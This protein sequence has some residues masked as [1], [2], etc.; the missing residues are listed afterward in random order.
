[1]LFAAS[2]ARRCTCAPARRGAVRCIDG[3]LH[4]GL[5]AQ[6][7]DAQAGIVGHGRQAGGRRG[8]PRLGQRV[9]DERVMRLLGLGHAERALGDQ[10]DR[11]RGEQLPQLGELLRVVRGQDQPHRMPLRAAWRRVALRTH[12]LANALASVSAVHLGRLNSAS[13]VPA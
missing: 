1:M 6:R 5:A 10:L 11:Q 12:Q 4:A 9:L 13:A 3:R 2:C 8:V 7:I